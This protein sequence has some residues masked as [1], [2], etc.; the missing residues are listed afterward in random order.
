MAR[1]TFHGLSEADCLAQAIA[2]V[3]NAGYVVTPIPTG[4]TSET[5]A[6]FV[7]RLGL[8][9]PTVIRRSRHPHAPS[10][11]SQRGPTG[12]ALRITSNPEFEKFCLENK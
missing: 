10:G 5:I 6:A 12:R 9:S 4:G 8:A 3:R 11:D 1:V 7:A 2:W